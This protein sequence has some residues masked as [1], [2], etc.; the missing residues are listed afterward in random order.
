MPLPKHLRPRWRYLVVAVETW[1][2]TA[3]TRRDLQGAVWA[4]GRALLGDPGSADA[5]LRVLQFRYSVAAG[6]GQALVRA[7]RSHVDDARAAIA[8]VDDVEGHPV[9]LF[10]EGVGGTVRSCEEKYLDEPP[11]VEDADA[12]FDG[13]KRRAT[14]H[15]DRVALRDGD[16]FTGATVLDSE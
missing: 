6:E 2:E 12:V 15:G 11:E 16:T 14:V 4:A 8:C 7:R 3:L 13:S 1:P 9:G 10:V 5:D